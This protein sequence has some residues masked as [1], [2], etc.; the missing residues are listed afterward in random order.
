VH[1]YLLPLA[2]VESH[3]HHGRRRGQRHIPVPHHQRQ[4]VHGDE[5]EESRRIG[6]E[7]DESEKRIKWWIH[8]RVAQVVDAITISNDPAGYTEV[9]QWSLALGDERRWG[10]E[11]SGSYGRL[12]G[13]YLLSQDELGKRNAGPTGKDSCHW[14]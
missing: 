9:Y 1:Y 4:R 7:N 11:N 10:I 5:D 12:L 3:Q 2:Y 6:I 14:A 8:G 13:Q